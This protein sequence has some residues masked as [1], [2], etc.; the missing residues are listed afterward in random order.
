MSDDIKLLNGIHEDI[1]SNDG[2]RKA[3]RDMQKKV[4]NSKGL[5]LLY[6][7]RNS[8]VYF[9]TQENIHKYFPQKAIQKILNKRV[10]ASNPEK[11]FV[12]AT[13]IPNGESLFNNYAWD[14]SYVLTVKK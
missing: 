4:H 14:A 11:D 10:E 13:V 12:L 1:L 7:S 3:L 9:V 5:F 8:N 6:V 2:Y